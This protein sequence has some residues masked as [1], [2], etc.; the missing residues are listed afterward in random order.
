[1]NPTKGKW[2][3]NNDSLE[4]VPLGVKLVLLLLF[5]GLNSSVSKFEVSSG[6]LTVGVNGGFTLRKFSQ[7]IPEQSE[8]EQEIVNLIQFELI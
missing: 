4:F 5:G 8:K 6:P 3:F 7:S 1:M 2:T